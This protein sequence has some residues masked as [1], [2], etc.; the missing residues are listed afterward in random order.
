VRVATWNVNGLRA[1]QGLL[2]HWLRARR[3]D[4]VALQEL[5]LEDAHFPHEALAAEGYQAVTHGQKSW[6]GVA[7]LAR[8]KPSVVRC[9]F[10]G[11]E[12]LGARLLSADVA[13]LRVTSLYVPNGKTILHEDFA[14]KL[15]WLEALPAALGADAEQASVLC[16]DFNLCPGPLDS[17]NEAAFHGRIFHTEAE[18]KRFE[19]LL[20][21]GWRDLF[22]ERHPERQAFSWWD[23][24][25]GSFHKGEGLRIDLVLGSQPVL[26]RLR[27]VEIDRE[28]RK[29]QDG[30]IASDH[31][32][33]W[34]EL[35]D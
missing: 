15:A 29:K 27:E 21:A 2:V 30:L 31:A 6:N 28:Y 8:E 5:K 34:V 4:V 18:R 1:R 11:Q 33:V 32:P 14:T 23:Y 16:G 19:A 35:A 24:R 17:W 13:G 12:A 10:P 26:A 7:I 22:R 20:A 3:P 9:G 25:A